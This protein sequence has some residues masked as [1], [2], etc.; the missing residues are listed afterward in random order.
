MK[1]STITG[2]IS[3]LYFLTTGTSA[4]PAVPDAHVIQKRSTA[5][6]EKIFA[7]FVDTMLWPTL[8]VN[9]ILAKT[10]TKY[11]SLGFLVADSKGQPAWGGITSY[12]Q[13]FYKDIIDRLRQNGGDVIPSFGGANGLELSNVAVSANSVAALY[14]EVIDLY[15][16]TRI[17]FDIEGGAISNQTATDIRNQAIKILQTNNPGLI[18]SYTLPVLPTG[19]T[20]EGVTIL[21]SAVKFGANIA[22]VNGMAMDYGSYAAPDGATK[23]G[24]YAIQVGESLYSQIQQAGLNALAGITPMI[25]VNDVQSEVFSLDNAR[26]LVNWASSSNKVSFLAFWS[27]NRDVNNPTGPLYASSQIQ[28]NDYD[29]ANI[30]VNYPSGDVEIPTTTSTKSTTKQTSTTSVSLSVTIKYETKTTTVYQDRTASVTFTTTETATAISVV[31][32]AHT[33]TV[34]EKETET[35]T[36]KQT[37][38]A[39]ISKERL[40]MWERDHSDGDA[41]EELFEKDWTIGSMQERDWELNAVKLNFISGPSGYTPTP[42]PVTSTSGTKKTIITSCLKTTS[43]LDAAK[44]TATT[45]ITSCPKRTQVVTSTSAKSCITTITKSKS[46]AKTT[47]TSTSTSKSSSTSAPAATSNVNLLGSSKFWNDTTVAPYVDITDW[48]TFD[49]SDAASKTGLL[50]YTLGF[51]VADA[52]NK[53]PSWGG[54]YN[55]ITGNFY[56]SIISKVRSYGGELIVS[57]GG[58]AGNELGYVISN[59]NDLFLAYKSVIDKFKFKWADFDIEGDALK[60]RK[61]IPIRNKALV[62]LKK[63]FPELIISFTLPVEINGLTDDASFLLSNAYSVGL[64]V[65]VVNLMTMNF[66]SWLL[67]QYSGCKSFDTDLGKC[68]IWAAKNTYDQLQKIGLKTTKVGITPMLGTNDYKELKFTLSHAKDVLDFA[69][70]TPYIAQLAYWSIN[71]DNAADT[72]LS[73]NKYDFANLW[74]SYDKSSK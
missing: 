31:D 10:G 42:F 9:T 49:I 44:P 5:W 67:G 54:W 1:V 61:S 34:T 28:Q 4:I 33:T 45:I 52:D 43:I 55:A 70:T 16:F 37:L 14:Q 32:G 26:E 71:R 53:T 63:A 21:T 51:I 74:K 11:F 46:T 69:N 17:D 8:D 35:K 24:A 20:A 39:I 59:E 36:E 66:G 72:N 56:E 47:S 30:F 62:L 65:D 38:T 22:V 7:P 18:V 41:V 27:C 25:G 6:P 57:F 73:I 12:S 13:G 15:A 68:S 23:M 2:A 58:A 29:F 50:H 19:L 40:E 64:Q 60:D 48:P 3:L